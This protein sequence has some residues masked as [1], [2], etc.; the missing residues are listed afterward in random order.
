M[1][2][3]NF[4]G[5]N[6]PKLALDV[7]FYPLS[8]YFFFNQIVMALLAIVVIIFICIKTTIYQKDLYM[9]VLQSFMEFL[10]QIHSHSAVGIGFKNAILATKQE[11]VNQR[12]HVCLDLLKKDI[13][14]NGSHEGITQILEGSFPIDEVK[15]FNVM[16]GQSAQTG[17]S[18]STIVSITIDQLYLKFKSQKEIDVLLFQKKLEQ[19]ILCAAPLM[20]I[21]SIRLA[22]PQYLSPLYSSGQ[23]TVIMMFAFGLLVLMKTI[24]EKIVK[25]PIKF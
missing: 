1:K 12:L 13:Q 18:V 17:T 5:L 15:I 19:T 10:N 7:F 6:M 9:T 23:G 22:S 2:K 24:S 25:I 3:F 21:A 8:M 4:Q 20:I 11:E 14:F 16:L